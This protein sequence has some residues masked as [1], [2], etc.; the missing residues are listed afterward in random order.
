MTVAMDLAVFVQQA[1]KIM[2]EKKNH[3]SNTINDG[4]ACPQKQKKKLETVEN[5][6]E[7]HT[8]SSN[9]ATTTTTE[10]KRP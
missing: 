10:K 9:E 5:E 4:N 6:H 7:R 1:T 2:I 8:A 3:A